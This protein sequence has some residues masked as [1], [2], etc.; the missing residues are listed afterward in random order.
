[1]LV[2]RDHPSWVQWTTDASQGV[3]GSIQL[4]RSQNLPGASEWLLK[5]LDVSS[6]EGKY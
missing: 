4:P 5:G 3:V 1:M 2:N 6:Q